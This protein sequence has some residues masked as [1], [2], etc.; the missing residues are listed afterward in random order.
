MTSLG[1]KAFNNGALFPYAKQRFRN[2]HNK[3]G[4]IRYICKQCKHK[5]IFPTFT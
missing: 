3:T 1:D 4:A 2:N 5:Q